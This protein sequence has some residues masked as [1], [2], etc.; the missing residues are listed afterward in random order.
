MPRLG[1]GGIKETTAANGEGGKRGRG[2]VE[3]RKK[4]DEYRKNAATAA[5]T[6][7]TYGFAAA[8]KPGAYVPVTKT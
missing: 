6:T 2:Q 4:H 1:G 8:A 3:S 7:R 5:T